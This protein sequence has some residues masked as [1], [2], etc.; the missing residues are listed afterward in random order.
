MQKQKKRKESSARALEMV[1]IAI[2]SGILL[3]LHPLHPSILL[4]L[5]LKKLD[6]HR[7]KKINF[8]SSSKKKKKTHMKRKATGIAVAE[9]EDGQ[10][11][12]KK[13]VRKA[14]PTNEAFKEQAKQQDE[15]TE[16]MCVKTKLWSICKSSALLGL[17]E[18]MVA[19]MTQM[20]FHAWHLAYAVVLRAIEQN[21]KLDCSTAFFKHCL[22]VCSTATNAH[23]TDS[24]DPERKLMRAL[25]EQ[26][27]KDILP[28]TTERPSRDLLLQ[29]INCE[30][31][32]MHTNASNHLVLHLPA[33]IRRYL[34]S[35]MVS[36]LY[37]R[38]M[39]QQR[40]EPLTVNQFDRWLRRMTNYVLYNKEVL[41]PPKDDAAAGKKR[42][43]T[44]K[45]KPNKS[46]ATETSPLTVGPLKALADDLRTRLH[47]SE[48]ENYSD[49][50]LRAHDRWSRLFP[51][52]HFI[53]QAQSQCQL[54]EDRLAL[55]P[56]GIRKHAQ[57]Q[58]FPL[59]PQRAA[60]HP[61]YIKIDNS[62]LHGL[63]NHLDPRKKIPWDSFQANKHFHWHHYFN[64]GNLT[65]DTNG[66]HQ[67]A[68]EIRTNGYAID[69]VFQKAVPKQPK[70]NEEKLNA[71]T[72]ADTV[73]GIDPGRRNLCTA[74]RILNYQDSVFDIDQLKTKTMP[75]WQQQQSVKQQQPKT[76]WNRRK[77]KAWRKRVKHKRRQLATTKLDFVTISKGLQRDMLGRRRHDHILA[78]RR[79]KQMEDIKT[80]ITKH[81]N[82]AWTS[83][84]KWQHYLQL[85]QIHCTSLLA[86][87]GKKVFR[88]IQFDRYHAEQVGWANI[89]TLL[90]NN[91]PSA[92]VAYGDGCTNS[93]SPGH[94]PTPIKKLHAEL[95]KRCTV[96]FINEFR[97]SILCSCCHAKMTHHCNQ[98]DKEQ[99]H[100]PVPDP[101]PAK[102]K[103]YDTTTILSHSTNDDAS[104]STEAD[105]IG[106]CVWN[107]DINA[108]KNILYLMLHAHKKGNDLKHR[109]DIFTR[110]VDLPKPAK[111]KKND[112]AE[113]RQAHQT[114]Q[115]LLAAYTHQI[116]IEIEREAVSASPAID[117]TTSGGATIDVNLVPMGFGNLILFF[118]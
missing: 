31:I 59:L 100:G 67:F 30:A 18:D 81:R 49:K 23:A 43:T 74:A 42:T 64:L 32:L 103:F 77:R 55:L 14:N 36:I 50:R 61:I 83:L 87:Y 4:C 16:F 38:E 10:Q 24:N 90:T 3:C 62:T 116:E 28:T 51:V 91:D 109:P 70:T 45:K 108:A 79:N 57:T 69:V 95:S 9:Q 63:H 27:F 52:L 106:A 12:T 113:Q 65:T 112:E 5:R 46:T 6:Q 117:G 114:D 58:S 80:E 15:K 111:E 102:K 8:F 72:M 44:R 56:R 1:T 26:T 88:M 82:Q 40:T 99:Q 53:Q 86:Y 41:D 85:F 96:I 101:R 105:T 78:S 92:V 29:A 97:T 47:F 54:S 84:V 110:A 89:C 107:R 33:R 68:E 75:L 93:T 21:V 60:Y 37:S 25:V 13:R 73:I 98:S 76:N 118:S 66:K 22:L 39:I 11:A 2:D 94:C 71:L 35:S 17:L 48:T 20:S 104:I 7:K 19:N 34:A 115:A